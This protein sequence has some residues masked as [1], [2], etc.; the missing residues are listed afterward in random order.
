MKNDITGLARQNAAR[1]EK[2]RPNKQVQIGN[3]FLKS[4]SHLVVPFDKGHGLYLMKKDTYRQKLSE[5]LRRNHFEPVPTS[6]RNKAKDPI[7][8]KKN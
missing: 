6:K 1:S 2:Q 4:K 7:I 8:K 5:L 3:K